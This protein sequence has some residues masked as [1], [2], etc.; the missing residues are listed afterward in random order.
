MNYIIDPS[1]FEKVDI[2][3]NT[4]VSLLKQYVKYYKQYGG[5]EDAFGTGGAT[6]TGSALQS[7]GID[8][9]EEETLVS[10]LPVWTEKMITLLKKNGALSDNITNE[11]MNEILTEPLYLITHKESGKQAYVLGL[12]H[13]IPLNLYGE[14]FRVFIDK[15]NKVVIETNPKIKVGNV[16]PDCATDD[17]IFNTF[18]NNITDIL[19]A[20]KDNNSEKEQELKTSF[21]KTPDIDLICNRKLLELNLI[22]KYGTD[23]QLVTLFESKGKKTDY[24]ENIDNQA[25]VLNGNNIEYLKR[26]TKYE[27]EDK[28]ELLSKDKKE[29]LFN[30]LFEFDNELNFYEGYTTIYFKDTDL[31]AIF[32]KEYASN[33]QTQ[34]N[35]NNNN[36]QIKDFIERHSKWI[37]KLHNIIMGQKSD[38]ICL[39]AIGVMHITKFEGVK[40]MFHFMK[41]LGYKIGKYNLHTEEIDYSE[42]ITQEDILTDVTNTFGENL[43]EIQNHNLTIINANAKP[44]TAEQYNE[45]KKQEQEPKALP[46]SFK[47]ISPDGSKQ[48]N[49]NELTLIGGISNLNTLNDNHFDIIN[50]MYNTTSHIEKLNL[51]HTDK[52]RLFGIHDM[53]ELTENIINSKHIK[54]LTISNCNEFTSLDNISELHQLEYLNI[55][56]NTKLT[57]IPDSIGQL[58]N[59]KSLVFNGN[60]IGKLPDFISGDDDTFYNR[61]KVF[62]KNPKNLKLKVFK[63]NSNIDTRPNKFPSEGMKNLFR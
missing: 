15:I 1:N 7:P 30:S 60:N 53:T 5:S 27:K 29:E 50:I 55:I 44:E 48:K 58:T 21:M 36:N 35:N 59:L 19:K 39:V 34:I 13:A 12:T 23:S 10:T 24:L 14:T 38:E 56:G 41:D 45:I 18:I 40:S 26:P 54:G 33:Y 46:D 9:N 4:G 37:D 20:K 17:K 43:I 6:K 47:Y 32:S 31:L 28:K 2:F 16:I 11:E 57:L 49:Y 42:Y 22:N 62:Q 3:S 52:I 51:K 25:D 63:N 61:L 8:D